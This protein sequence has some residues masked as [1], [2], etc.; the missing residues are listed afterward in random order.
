MSAPHLRDIDPKLAIL[1]TGLEY[2][3][4]TNAD[5]AAIR[6]A[7]AMPPA[8]KLVNGK[9]TGIVVLVT[10]FRESTERYYE[11]IR[12]HQARGEAVYTMDWRGQGGSQRYHAGLPQRPGAQGYEHD[13][14]DLDQFVTQI[15][16]IDERHPGIPKTLHA[17][18]MGGNIALRYL[19]DYP[20]RFDNAVI[21]SPMLSIKTGIVPPFIAKQIAKLIS[22]FDKYR[23]LPGEG[24]WNEAEAMAPLQG[25]LNQRLIRQS[26]HDIIYREMPEKRIGGA[27]AGW[28]VEACRS[29][30]VLRDPAYL[31]R[32]KTPIMLVAGKLDNLVDPESIRRAAKH[33]PNATLHYYT[34]VGHSP[35]MESDATRNK[36]WDRVNDFMAEQAGK[37]P[38]TKPGKS[39]KA[40]RPAPNPDPGMAKRLTSGP[41]DRPRAAPDWPV[42]HG[43]NDRRPTKAAPASPRRVP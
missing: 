21:T 17:H 31:K 9:P 35:W 20:D 6:Y 43:A 12:E 33:L 30:S 15:A 1:P 27:T 25:K 4:F 23:Y 7:R 10:G 18:S 14:A 29:I 22:Y 19:H 2:G 32:I 34:R 40:T 8:D 26:L 28:F 3:T 24:D 36:I 42:K 16:R 41:D 37:A 5:G 11:K 39:A 13:A 38:N